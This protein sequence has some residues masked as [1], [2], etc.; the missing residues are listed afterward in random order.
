MTAASDR[1]LAMILGLI[2][3]LLL[4]L[5]GIVSFA[6]GFAYLALGSGYRAVG[7]ALGQSVVLVVVGLVVG[8]LSLLGRS[9]GQ[10][11]AVVAGIALIV[12]A[13]VG[14]LALGLGYGVLGILAVVFAFLAGIF[15]LLSRP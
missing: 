1:R 2:S 5:D 14:W 15:F 7:A 12:I 4:V 11:R 6:R 10:D 8:I 13:I 9:P 3:A